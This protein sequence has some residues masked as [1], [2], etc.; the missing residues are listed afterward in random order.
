LF[1]PIVSYYFQ[2]SA[3]VPAAVVGA[4]GAD[5]VDGADGADGADVSA[6]SSGGVSIHHPSRTNSLKDYHSGE[7][8]SRG[9]ERPD[10]CLHRIRRR[11]DPG[12]SLSTSHPTVSHSP[13]IS[14][15]AGGLNIGDIISQLEGQ[16]AAN[17][18]KNAAGKLQRFLY[19]S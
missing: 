11:G 10:D 18:A 13:Q 2:A 9:V 12:E 16:A 17:A 4:D 15:N 8:R 7:R 1:H 3:A 5:G 6:S 19:S 14:G